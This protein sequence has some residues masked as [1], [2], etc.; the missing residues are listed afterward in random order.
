MLNWS[1]WNV[2]RRL[3]T[4]QNALGLLPLIVER[5]EGLHD[6]RQEIGS[7]REQLQ[8]VQ[9]ALGR[10]EARQLAA[11][12]AT[13]L[14]EQEFKVT[15]QF[16][17]DGIIQYLLRHVP[18]DSKVFVEFGVEDY[19]EANTLFLL[20]QNKWAGLVIDGSEDNVRRIQEGRAHV[21][22]NLTA[23]QAFVTRDNINALLTDNG[24]TG[25]I[26]LL[27]ID[28]DGNDYWVWEAVTAVH[29]VLV[30]VEYNHR[31]GS[32]ASVTIPYDPEFV[33]TQAHPSHTYFGASL[34]AL[35]GLAHRKG[36]AF[37]GTGSDGVNAFFVRRDKRPEQVPELS[38]EEG[39]HQGHFSEWFGQD[40]RPIHLSWEEQHALVMGLPLVQVG[41]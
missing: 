7:I 29:P 13:S 28:I 32:E 23:V 16:G 25:E 3:A 18:I 5:L 34:R 35:C 12:P 10:M 9:L 21:F 33:R 38:V 6:I 30:I 39:Y 14:R 37:V 19:T 8:H 26:G 2:A 22:Y 36:Y 17:E 41:E 15:S 11:S 4:V 40:G 24:F 27:S 20:E 31:F 1:K